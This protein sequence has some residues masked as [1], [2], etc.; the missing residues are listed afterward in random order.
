MNWCVNIMEEIINLLK[1]IQ[2]IIGNLGTG[3]DETTILLF[4]VLFD[5]IL[6]IS[7]RLIK[8]NHHMISN[9]AL[10]GILRNVLVSCIPVLLDNVKNLYKHNF[11]IYNFMN[12][13]FTIIIAFGILQSI[14][15][16]LELNG[17]CP[18]KFLIKFYGEK[19]IKNE[20]ESKERK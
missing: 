9:T 2:A 3:I 7:W 4:M 6:A 17:I 20:K 18:P 1:D 8:R 12:A 10:Q 14:I 11:Y 5:S 16:N 13:I 15:A 19:T